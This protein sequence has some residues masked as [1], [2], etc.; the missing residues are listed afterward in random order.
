[1]IRWPI[2]ND[3]PHQ[4]HLNFGLIEKGEWGVGMT[5]GIASG[6]DHFK[7]PHGGEIIVY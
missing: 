2:V 4:S 5:H 7:N 3:F 1:M 6:Y